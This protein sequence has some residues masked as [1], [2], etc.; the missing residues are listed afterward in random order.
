MKIAIMGTTPHA[1]AIAHLLAQHGGH[2]ISVSDAFK[3]ER[4]APAAAGL[5]D[6]A[7]AETPYQ[8]AAVS[9]VLIL[10][11]RW[12]DLDQALLAMGTPPDTAVIVDATKPP[13]PGPQ[14]GAQIIAHRLDSH[15][16]VEAFTQTPEPGC[17]ISLCG[18]DPDAKAV[19]EGLIR[20][21]GCTPHDLGGLKHAGEIESLA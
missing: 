11:T 2:E 5:G 21:M 6:D 13:H 20:E 8:Q 10:A 9:D 12:E 16:V 3:P 1:Q 7:I 17:T 18:D 19:V 14:S 15:R 4:A